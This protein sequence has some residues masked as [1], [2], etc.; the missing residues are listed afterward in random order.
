MIFTIKRVVVCV[1]LFFFIFLVYDA[2]TILSYYYFNF[3]NTAIRIRCVYNSLFQR[4]I[5]L[6]W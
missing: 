2:K 5:I 3:I 1:Y 4:I 6:L